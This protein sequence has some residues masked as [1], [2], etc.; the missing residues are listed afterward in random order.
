MRIQGYLSIHPDLVL[1]QRLLNWFWSKGRS[2]FCLQ[3][4]YQYGPPQIRQVS[5]AQ[6]IMLILEKH[7]WARP[8]EGVEIDGKCHKKAWI[9]EQLT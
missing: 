6:A 8:V 5:K 2:L 9:I 3:E 7:G 1:A 4:I